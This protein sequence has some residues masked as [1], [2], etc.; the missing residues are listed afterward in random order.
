[1]KGHEDD[2]E[3]NARAVASIRHPAWGVFALRNSRYDASA[4][5]KR[6]GGWGARRRSHVKN[7]RQNLHCGLKVIPSAITV[8]L[9][10]EIL[11]ERPALEQTLS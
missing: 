10:P 2:H 4:K 9:Q 5:M 6:A 11:F 1:M 8:H 7:L 3:C